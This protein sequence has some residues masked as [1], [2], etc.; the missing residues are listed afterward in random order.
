MNNDQGKMEVKYNTAE[1]RGIYYCLRYR[2][3]GRDMLCVRYDET[4][5]QRFANT[6]LSTWQV[7]KTACKF[8]TAARI[9]LQSRNDDRFRSYT[10]KPGLVLSLAKV[11][12]E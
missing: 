1:H 11:L 4:A 7:N 9:E 6:Q 2:R 3:L 10:S 5:K 8:S 12:E